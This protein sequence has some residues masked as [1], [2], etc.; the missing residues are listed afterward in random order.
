MRG[1][2]HRCLLLLACLLPSCF[3]AVCLFGPTSAL[4]QQLENPRQQQDQFEQR[5][6][7]LERIAPPD[8]AVEPRPRP[9]PR[10]PDD[11]CIE[12][13]EIEISGA[14]L[15]SEELLEELTRPYEGRC[16][17]LG[18]LNAL[19]DEINQS[20]IDRGYVTSRALLP[21]QDL[22]G[23]V[24]RLIVVEGRIEGFRF[25]DREGSD[26]GA[27]WMAF[28]GLT[29]DTLDLREL[30][31]GLEQMNRLR[32]IDARLS[33]EPGE[34]PG[35][36]RVVIET[37]SERDMRVG[38]GFDTLGGERTGRLRGRMTAEIDNMLGLLDGW[39]GYLERSLPNQT[40]GRSLSA[41]G[42]LS[43]PYGRFTLLSEV[44]YSEYLQFVEGTAAEF[45]ISGSTW[46]AEGGVSWVLGR[47]QRSKTTLEA[48]YGLKDTESFLD[49]LELE[50]GTRRLAI[51]EARLSQTQR[52]LGGAWFATLAVERGLPR[53]LGTSLD[54]DPDAP[55]GTPRAQFTK[56]ALLLDGIQPLPLGEASLLWR[57]SLRAEW[58]PDTLFG[59]ERMTL[60]GYFTVRGFRDESIAGDEG[61]LLRNDLVW[62][63][64]S[65]GLGR[66]EDA[67]G[68]I[69][70]YGAFDAGWVD[71]ADNVSDADGGIAGTAVG[72]RASGGP[73][74]FDAN[75]A[76]SVVQGPL[77]SE[78]LVFTFRAGATF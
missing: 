4:A 18:D 50:T 21:E 24:L 30:E 12:V 29:G 38:G 6:R 77:E 26:V 70:L 5:Q 20:Y 8:D 3:G 32:A 44:A 14:T 16:L 59:S 72:L 11:A 10:Q 52:M 71:D 48:R 61:V 22:T 64:P 75:L 15:L 73:L 39:S 63:L 37:P 53:D 65:L 66:V 7:E 41:G 68:R 69:E 33:I 27:V 76:H 9:L 46:R 13:E 49:D 31:Q 40:D 74:T 78:G 62:T 17:S 43:I 35:T 34:E 2:L 58:S 42:F 36:S 57:P 25:N 51:A 1:L 54:D 60:G 55:R 28:P 23:G 19:L 67:L 47:G 56:A 45:A